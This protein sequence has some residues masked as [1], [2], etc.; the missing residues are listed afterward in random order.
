MV[1]YIDD[2]VKVLSDQKE[3]RNLGSVN[4]K[5][6]K[7]AR[8]EL[9]SKNVT[10]IDESSD[11]KRYKTNSTPKDEKFNPFG[12]GLRIKEGDPIYQWSNVAKVESEIKSHTS[13]LTF[14]VKIFNIDRQE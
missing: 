13:Y 7:K 5:K 9:E 8:Q 3:R 10:E 2:A 12:K 11:L 14:A 4:Y 6:L 1:K